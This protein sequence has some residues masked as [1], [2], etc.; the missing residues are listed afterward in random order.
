M[1]HDDDDD[2]EIKLVKL[3]LHIVNFQYVYNISINAVHTCTKAQAI[4]QMMYAG[5]RER[6]GRAKVTFI[7]FI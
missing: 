7:Y 5:T 3:Q 1:L 2:V 4:M 6:C